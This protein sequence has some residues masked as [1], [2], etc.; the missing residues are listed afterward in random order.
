MFGLIA[1]P[2]LWP[3]IRVRISIILYRF[4]HFPWKTYLSASAYFAAD[5]DGEV[6]E[7]DLL[8]EAR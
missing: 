3:P 1:R 8:G 2:I 4:I 6:K 5:Y 7:E